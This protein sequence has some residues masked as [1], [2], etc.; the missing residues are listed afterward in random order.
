MI[1]MPVTRPRSCVF[2]SDAF[3]LH[4]PEP[5]RRVVHAG[6]PY[7]RRALPLWEALADEF[8][9]NTDCLLGLAGCLI[10]IGHVECVRNPA[11]GELYYRRALQLN[12][13]LADQLPDDM[14]YACNWW[15]A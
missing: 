14:G 5:W 6:E 9:T 13:K 12:E 2:V 10:N 15:T 4:Q 3:S 11:D 7:F 1:S 8:P